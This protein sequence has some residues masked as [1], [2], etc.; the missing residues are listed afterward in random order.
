MVELKVETA[1][2][3]SEVQELQVDVKELTSQVQELTMALNKY[4]GAA[5]FALLLVTLIM[6]GIGLVFQYLKIKGS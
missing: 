5:G 6:S 2:I 1:T 3:K 4:K